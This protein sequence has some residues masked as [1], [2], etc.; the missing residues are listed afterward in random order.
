MLLS[1]IK[2][3]C[4]P[5]FS[6]LNV[7]FMPPFYICEEQSS[8]FRFVQSAIFSESS[9][10]IEFSLQ[11]GS[12]IQQIELKTP[13]QFVYLIIIINCLFEN[14]H[15]FNQSYSSPRDYDAT[16]TVLTIV[17]EKNKMNIIVDMYKHNITLLLVLFAVKSMHRPRPIWRA[18]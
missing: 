13:H 15:I 18:K 17:R 16:Q 14:R 12:A 6:L 2:I 8:H 1:G 4:L 5:R 7:L 11:C 3:G 9:W 10:L